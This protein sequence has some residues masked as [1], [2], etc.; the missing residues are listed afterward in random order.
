MKKKD[1]FEELRLDK[2]VR[3]DLKDLSFKN[4]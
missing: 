4:N 1:K 3:D 2:R